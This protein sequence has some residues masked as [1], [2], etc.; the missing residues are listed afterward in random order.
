[1]V[2]YKQQFNIKSETTKG[3]KYKVSESF[4]GKWSCSCPYW[5]Y[6]HQECKHIKQIK[7]NLRLMSN[8]INC[9]ITLTKV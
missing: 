9:G 3:I 5:I 6:R 7:F 1:M 2:R 4:S 8:L